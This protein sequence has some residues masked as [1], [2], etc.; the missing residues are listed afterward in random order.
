MNVY[1]CIRKNAL[2]LHLLDVVLG[3]RLNN[4]LSEVKLILLVNKR[5]SVVKTIRLSN[6]LNDF[7][8]REAQKTSQTVSSLTSKILISYRDR[9]SLIDKLLPV[10]L[11]PTTLTLLLETIEDDELIRLGP[12]IAHKMLMYNEHFLGVEKN[13]EELDYCISEMLPTAHWFSCFRSDDGYLITHQMGKKWGVFLSSFLSSLV[14]I[15]TGVRGDLVVDGGVIVLP[16]VA[17]KSANNEGE[18]QINRKPKLI[19]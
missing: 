19:P 16:S 10:S 13:L 7:L 18:K 9:Y 1:T 14:E 5:Q 15:Q 2:R 6:D 4:C 3:F 11:L 17:R 8:N 12:L